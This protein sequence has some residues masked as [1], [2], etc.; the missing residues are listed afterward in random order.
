MPVLEVFRGVQLSGGLQTLK[1]QLAFSPRVDHSVD[2]APHLPASRCPTTH[3]ARFRLSNA[4][5]R[6]P[7]MWVIESRS[8]A[9]GHLDAYEKGAAHRR[10]PP[11]GSSGSGKPI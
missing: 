5:A 10:S 3:H 9:C 11:S 1:A 6:F 8:D 4:S 2:V 7:E